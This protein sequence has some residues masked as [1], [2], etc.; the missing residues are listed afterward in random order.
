MVAG[1]G[2]SLTRK[3]LGGASWRVGQGPR[4]ML[5][6]HS[7]C[8]RHLSVPGV[9]WGGTG[10]RAS[11]GGSMQSFWA[12]APPWPPRTL[13][14]CCPPFPGSLEEGNMYR[15][16]V[17]AGSAFGRLGQRVTCDLV[18]RLRDSSREDH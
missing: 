12:S 9:S 3:P 7:R 11:R 6:S 13:P 4:E 10:L 5:G 15:F 18:C 16:T 17:T 1:M 14:L 2:Q 8:R